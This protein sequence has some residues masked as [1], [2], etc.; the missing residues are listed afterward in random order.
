MIALLSNVTID[1]LALQAEKFLEE[2]VLVLPGFD[3]WKGEL[4]N[5][6]SPLWRDDVGLI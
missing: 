5:P 1:S 3:T 2:K 4:L 6:A